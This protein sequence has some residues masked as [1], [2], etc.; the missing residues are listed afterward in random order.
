[1]NIKMR[2]SFIALALMMSL[3]L[4]VSCGDDGN[5]AE[6]NVN[7]RPK[8]G[9]QS[10]GSISN[11]SDQIF[12]AKSNVS[13]VMSAAKSS[14]GA[15]KI[16]KVE[17]TINDANGNQVSQENVSNA[18]FETSVS[19]PSGGI[20]TLV[21][22]AVDEAD[23][24][25]TKVEQKV[26][27]DTEAPKLKKDGFTLLVNDEK[28]VLGSDPI[29][30][31]QGGTVSVQ[32][33]VQDSISGNNDPDA[34][35]PSTTVKL[36]VN[37]Q[38][39]KEAKG[40]ALSA[41]LT[42]DSNATDSQLI[43]LGVGRYN[44]SISAVDGAGN[45]A[46]I[47]KFILQVAKSSSTDSTPPE[48]T[49]LQPQ[50]NAQLRAK[51]SL[52]LQ[53]KEPE[54]D[55]SQL[56]I[57]DGSSVLA[58]E[59]SVSKGLFTKEI[60]TTTLSD[61]DHT[62]RVVVVNSEGLSGEAQVAVKVDNTV[63]VV[64]WR[65]P[66]ENATLT[67]RTTL[68]I[69]ASD[70][71]G[72]KASDIS[73]MLGTVPIPGTPKP[74]G[75]TYTLEF[76]SKQLGLVDGS[77]VLKAIVRDSFGNTTEATR[78]VTVSNTDTSK[79]TVNWQKP[80]AGANI[81]GTYSLEVQATDKDNNGTK[82]PVKS[83]TLYVGSEK[84][85]EARNM[86][87]D[88]WRLSWDTT[89]VADG[90]YS[91]RAEAQ[92]MSGNIHKETI[93]VTVSNAIPLEVSL[94][95]NR[96]EPKATYPA[97]DTECQSQI[98]TTQLDCYSGIVSIPVTVNDE[99]GKAAVTLIVK[100][101]ALGT[102][103]LGV[104]DA[105]PYIFTLDTSNYPNNDVLTI[106]ARARR[107]Q[108]GKTVTSG[109]INIGIYNKKP[110]PT[111]AITSPNNGATLQ[112]L[113]DVSFNISQP[114]GTAYTL[115]LDGKNG[116][117]AADSCGNDSKGKARRE[118]FLLEFID[119]TSKVVAEQRVTA[120]VTATKSGA[121]RTLTPFKT[122]D[123]AN[124]TYFIRLSVILRDTNAGTDCTKLTEDNFVT[125]TRSIQVTTENANKVPPSLLIQEPVNIAGQPI[126]T[127]KNGTGFVVVNV[128]DNTTLAYVE[129]RIFSD[130]EDATT[131][132][133]RYICSLR[134]QISQATVALPVNPNA[135]PYL[136]TGDYTIR[137][138]AQDSEKNRTQQ[139]VKVRIDRSATPYSLSV[140]PGEVEVNTGYGVTVS[141]KAKTH[142]FLEFQNTSLCYGTVR[143]VAT[144]SSS[145][146]DGKSAEGY[147]VYGAQVID[148][149]N[150]IYGTNNASVTVK[151]KEVTP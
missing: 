97:A 120:G 5:G 60:D 139:E 3:L 58:T 72:L 7:L 21:A 12:V 133:S 47:R 126:P 71:N 129:L 145:L 150:H 112:G 76:D 89:K 147:Y 95:V 13:V 83:V 77:Y 149:N 141:P 106:T 26:I 96:I 43:K 130:K 45:E 142:T 1:M 86:V 18:P 75:N 90:A 81:S 56:I 94:D 84:L 108:D 36:S 99:T 132:P 110:L 28:K 25:S 35:T 102:A 51:T 131:T 48:I 128:S 62:L 100:S 67:G 32:V 41:T 119:F 29:Q 46:E 33:M 20:Y 10:I 6:P 14:Q 15:T 68:K 65:A 2:N 57:F 127:Y 19:F 87:D 64:S 9:F 63:P 4:L 16:A 140:N 117:A 88:I 103:P 85:G 23:R 118:G 49:I 82:Q 74:E 78:R 34:G 109:A 113:V 137:V 104:D 80:A 124:D 93:N 70:N 115:D 125:L 24:R 143:A 30:I 134:N 31:L 148:N 123:L 121:Y 37:G 73:F 8:V 107:N 55:I 135:D 44:I 40:G 54:S 59:T 17:L 144:S 92:D 101:E 91:L 105:A 27:V 79:P 151:P 146:G 122:I 114:A 42:S 38:V 138:I 22:V 61:G 136:P 116:V 111:I 11:F 98:G 66:L 39:K 50:A 52:Q 69:Q 53:I